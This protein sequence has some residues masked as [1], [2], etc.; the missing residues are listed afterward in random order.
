MTPGSG[1][2]TVDLGL[3]AVTEPGVGPHTLTLEFNT[4]CTG[5]GQTGTITNVQIDTAAVG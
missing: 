2:Q 5:G 1:A 3:A 4:N